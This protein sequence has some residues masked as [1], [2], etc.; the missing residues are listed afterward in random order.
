M[1]TIHAASLDV[2][3][4]VTNLILISL[5]VPVLWFRAREVR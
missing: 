5:T 3:P 2:G 4:A 1:L